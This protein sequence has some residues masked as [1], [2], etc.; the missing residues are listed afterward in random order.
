MTIVMP[1]AMIPGTPTC[2][3][4]L[5]RFTG[6]MNVG[7]REAPREDELKAHD[8]DNEADEDRKDREVLP[9]FEGGDPYGRVPPFPWLR[10]G[11]DWL[12]AHIVLSPMEWVRMFSS[13]TSALVSSAM[14]SPSFMT[15]TRSLM[16]I[17]SGMSEDTMMMA[18]PCFRR[19]TMIW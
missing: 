7:N 10:C 16:E 18:F 19:F 12:N 8:D 1:T 4:M 17:T 14:T 5:S 15:R 6:L 2:W 9:A 3:R 13:V 11:S